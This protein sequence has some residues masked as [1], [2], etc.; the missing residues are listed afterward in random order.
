MGVH[1]RTARAHFECEV[2][3]DGAIIAG[4]REAGHGEAE[5]CDFDVPNKFPQRPIRTDGPHLVWL[6]VLKDNQ[7]FE[8][9]FTP[10][11]E[12]AAQSLSATGLLRSAPE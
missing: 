12:K 1:D 6:G 5:Y 11:A 9:Q 8:N 2:K 3:Q 10:L 4:H 7:T